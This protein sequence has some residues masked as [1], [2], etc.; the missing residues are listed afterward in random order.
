M[1]F[2]LQYGCRS[3]LILL[4]YYYFYG[5]DKSNFVFIADCVQKMIL[6]IGMC[7]SENIA[8]IGGFCSFP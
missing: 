8:A 4:Y 5:F 6:S 3:S 1:C 2:D 7:F